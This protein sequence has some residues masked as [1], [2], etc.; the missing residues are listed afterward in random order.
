MLDQRPAGFPAARAH[1]K[2]DPEQVR[3]RRAN[4]Q[5]QF[6]E[7]SEAERFVKRAVD[8]QVAV[9]PQGEGVRAQLIKHTPFGLRSGMVAR[10]AIRFLAVLYYTSDTNPP[11]CRWSRPATSSSSS[12]IRTTAAERP[13]SRTRSSML[14]GVGPSNST[15]R[16]RSSLPGS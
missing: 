9:I 6:P 11:P 8:E 2:S 1:K 10:K 3:D 14:T 12:T 13:E 5:F 7:Y 15:M 4:H 16:L